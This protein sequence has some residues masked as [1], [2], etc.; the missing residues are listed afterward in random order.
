MDVAPGDGASRFGNG[1][2]R[3]KQDHPPA[4]LVMH[5]R[6]WDWDRLLPA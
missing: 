4:L 3:G 2:S 5:A 6:A 1:S